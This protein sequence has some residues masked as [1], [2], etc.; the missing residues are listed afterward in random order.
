MVDPE[1]ENVRLAVQEL[2][3]LEEEFGD[4]EWPFSGKGGLDEIPVPAGN[5]CV[6]ISNALAAV[7]KNVSENMRDLARNSPIHQ[8]LAAAIENM[9]PDNDKFALLLTHKYTKTNIAPSGSRALEGVDH[10]RFLAL[11]EANNFVSVEKKLQFRIAQLDHEVNFFFAHGNI[12]GRYDVE[13]HE[14]KVEKRKIV[15]NGVNM[16]PRHISVCTCQVLC[17]LLLQAD[18]ATLVVVFFSQFFS[19]LEEKHEVVVDIAELLN[20]FDWCVVGEVLMKAL[21]SATDPTSQHLTYI[22]QAALAM[23]SGAKFFA[24]GYAHC[25]DDDNLPLERKAL[26]VAIMF[27]RIEW[28]KKQVQVLEKPFSWEMPSRHSPIIGKW[29]KC[30]S[31]YQFMSDSGSGDAQERLVNQDPD[32]NED[33]GGNEWPFSD[34]GGLHEIPVPT[35]AA[36]VQISNALGLNKNSNDFSFG[37]QADQLP[38][39]P[40]IFVDGVGPI[41]VPLWEERAQRL[42]EKCTKSP[43]GHN[44]D[45]EMDENVRKS[46]ELQPDQVHF[47]NPMWRVGVEKMAVTI[48]ER[49]WYKG[50]P[51]QCVLYKILVYGEGGHF[52]KHQDTEKEDGMIATLVVQPPSLHEGGDLVVYRN[53]EVKHRHDFGKADGTA[54]EVTKG[55]RLAL[56]YSICLPANMRDFVRTPSMR[57]ELTGAIENMTPGD[58]NFAL[59]LAHEYTDRSIGLFGSTALKGVDRERFLALEEANNSVSAEKNL[60]F[61]IAH[62]NF[63]NPAMETY[64]QLWESYGSSESSGYLGNEGP[65]KDSIYSRFAIVAWPA[66][67]NVELTMKFANLSTAFVILQNRGPIDSATLL[68]YMDVAFTKLA[69]IDAF[70]L[71]RSQAGNSIMANMFLSNFFAR[72][73]DKCTV[74]L[75]IAKLVSEFSW[76]VV[77]KAF[78]EAVATIDGMQADDYS[79]KTTVSWLKN[80]ARGLEQPFS[81]AMPV[82]EFPDC[83]PIEKFL[84]G[85]EATMTTTGIVS[86]ED[87]WAA[88]IY[89]LRYTCG[90]DRVGQIDASFGMKPGGDKSDAF[91]TIT[92]TRK[93]YDKD[94]ESLPQ[95][96]KELQ[97]L[98]KTMVG[99]LTKIIL[100]AR[101]KSGEK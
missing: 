29:L 51:L 57:G 31:R 74:A 38:A 43:F 18:D 25:L 83:A 13:Y 6:K 101:Q 24:M 69:A 94:R 73:E 28:L 100:K 35:G 75:D 67:D 97:E 39:V 66:V 30:S 70:L 10:D 40:G 33:F 95:L 45:T 85:P 48:G 21:R 47:K 14:E 77:V 19:R 3:Y 78:S 46:W 91:V 92:K 50:I 32:L 61:H 53:G 17:Q 89:A 52:L 59:L 54:T 82:A 34:K 60:Q 55:Y 93:W 22:T 44:M 65:Q 98:T 1:E 9:T 86:F 79:L 16:F 20:K 96:K 76:V 23:N 68:K 56:V 80:K 64:S 5:A 12:L 81:W 87:S 36:C 63:L 26:L 72:L 8:E 99:T 11:V 2:K 90:W 27:S 62:L 4:K 37:G 15:W 49:L 71:E 58:D 7:N 88:Q 42:I 41:P 84:R